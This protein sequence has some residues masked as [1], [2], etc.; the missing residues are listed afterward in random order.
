MTDIKRQIGALVLT[1]Q[2][3]ASGLALPVLKD[4]PAFFDSLPLVIVGEAAKVTDVVGAID[5]AFNLAQLSTKEVELRGVE[6]FATVTG[7][8]SLDTPDSKLYLEDRINKIKSTLTGTDLEF[9]G[10]G[11]TE[12]MDGISYEYSQYLSVGGKMIKYKQPDVAAGMKDPVYLVELG[13]SPSSG[14]YLVNLWV[15]FTKTFNTSKAVGRELKLF[16]KSFTISS[17]TD[18][19][20]LVLFGL[21]GETEVKAGETA[22]VVVGDKTYKVEVVGIIDHSKAI[23]RV[24]RVTKEVVEGNTYDFAG[25]SVYVKDVFYYKVPVETGSVVVSIGGDRYVFE[26]GQ[27]IRRGPAGNEVEVQGTRVAIS[28]SPQSLSKLDIYFDA[29][30]ASPAVDYIKE[31]AVW[32]DP[33]FGVKVAYNGPVL[34]NTDTITVS[35]GGTTYY[36]VSFTDKYGKSGNVVWSYYD[37]TG[38]KLADSAGNLIHVVEGVGAKLNE[39]LFAVSPQFPRMLKVVSLDVRGGASPSCKATLRDVFSGTEYKV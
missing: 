29:Y 16:G 5:M 35:P 4:Y 19:S 2:L 10:S 15:T 22:D 8:V 26:N 27:P 28:A 31:K 17:E 9:L 13:T 39:Y 36:T 1:L 20:K 12:D 30:S 6:G 23:L 33:V 3:I 21:A 24:G 38:E 34:G 18:S 11:K 32:V 37:T 14:A 25:V 7:G